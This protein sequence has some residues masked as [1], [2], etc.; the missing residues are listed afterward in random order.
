MY[1]M[2]FVEIGGI[3]RATY[4]AGLILAHFA[5]QQ[6][7]KAALISE[8]FMVQAESKK[9]HASYISS[10]N[11]HEHREDGE[12]DLG[13]SSGFIFDQMQAQMNQGKL[14]RNNVIDIIDTIVRRTFIKTSSYAIFKNFF[15]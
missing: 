11:I 7:Y 5:A 13:H 10:S 14:S 8:L 6:L 15:V 1:T 12:D 9:P 2:Y 4:I 3:S